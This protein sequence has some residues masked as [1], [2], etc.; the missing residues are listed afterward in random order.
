VEFIVRQF[1]GKISA[2]IA[3][4]ILYAVLFFAAW[5]GQHVAPQF[6]ALYDPATAAAK[7]W[8]ILIASLNIAT[9]HVKDKSLKDTLQKLEDVMS[10]AGAPEIPVKKAEP[11]N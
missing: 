10:A 4:V 5:L 1:A 7:I 6:A 8:G 2:A 9:N 11:V 3:S